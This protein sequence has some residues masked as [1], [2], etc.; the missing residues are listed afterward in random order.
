MSIEIESLINKIKQKLELRG[1]SSDFIREK[2]SSEIKK[3]KLDLKKIKEKDL[4][5]LIKDLRS[6]L[7][8][9]S[10][11]F[12]TNDQDEPLIEHLSTRE[13]LNDLP[14][15]K[16]IFEKLKVKS[17]VDLGC[18]VNPIAL[19]S[20]SIKYDGYDIDG[21]ALNQVNNFFIKNNFDGRTHLMDI[22]KEGVSFPS[23]DLFLLLKV[24][25]VIERR[26]HKISE[27][28]IKS[29]PSK[30]ILVSFPKITVSGRPMNHPQRGWIERM[31]SRI[32][33]KYTKLETKNEIY[34]LVFKIEVSHQLISEVQQLQVQKNA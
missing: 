16:S 18:G 23:A 34:Y 3:S 33:L 6:D 29:I 11:R 32:N 2:I 17:V 13:R 27:R 14:L 26:G 22:S 19:A 30:Y 10:G 28:I 4:K 15:I 9:Y 21:I 8:K 25:D 5:L 7:R 31:L 1:I 20:R 24:L 12:H